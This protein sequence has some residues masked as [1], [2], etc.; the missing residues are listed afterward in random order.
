METIGATH[1]QLAERIGK[2]RSTVSNALRLLKLPL[3]VRLLVAEGK[4]SPGHARAL[5][6][7][8]ASPSEMAAIASAII[9]KGWSVRE[10]ERWAKQQLKSTRPAKLPDPNAAAAAERL[11]LILGTKVDIFTKSRNAGEI[12]IHYYSQED[13]MRLYEILTTGAVP[14]E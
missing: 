8:N 6:A 7:S 11:R 2:D 1:E 13:L 10:A 5:L 4:L 14:S 12:R 3:P 9:E